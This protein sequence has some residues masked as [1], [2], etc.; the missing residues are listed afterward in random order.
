MGNVEP[1][2]QHMTQSAPARPPVP[3]KKTVEVSEDNIYIK[4]VNNYCAARVLNLK[5]WRD[6]GK[7]YLQF[8]VD[9]SNGGTQAHLR[10]VEQWS[11]PRGRMIGDAIDEQR[12]AI[13][14]KRNKTVVLSGPT[15][16][17][18]AATITLY[19]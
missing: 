16:A 3:C 1:P 5:T 4:V 11:D 18:M 13:E 14:A 2:Q 7:T 17:A 6:A 15:P 12:I 19:K 8:D 10:L 9:N